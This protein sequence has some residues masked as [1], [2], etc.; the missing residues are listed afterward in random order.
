LWQSNEDEIDAENGRLLDEAAM[1]KKA[2][3]SPAPKKEDPTALSVDQ[4]Q[5]KT[6]ADA[7][8][9]ASLQPTVQAALTLMDYNK[10]FGDMPINTLLA[11]LGKQCV[12]ASKGDL[13][14]GEALLTAQ[15]HTLD[16][17]FNNL[18]RRAALNAGNTWA[19]AK[20]ICAW[21]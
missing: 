12:L 3:P 18:A 7:L 15:A 2:P 14:R 4:Q 8:A 5:T 6:P 21:R 13:S 10:A 19:R 11:D 20:R 16:A 9:R 1:T 17:I